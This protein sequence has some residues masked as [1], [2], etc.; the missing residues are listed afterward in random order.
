MIGSRLHA[1]H[2]ASPPSGA[3]TGAT[4]AVEASTSSSGE[5]RRFPRFFNLTC[6]SLKL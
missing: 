6:L 5:A 3:R 4:A 2:H 1:T